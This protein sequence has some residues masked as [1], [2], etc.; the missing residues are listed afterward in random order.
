MKIT[1]EEVRELIATLEKL[2]LYE[3]HPRLSSHDFNVM[4]QLYHMKDYKS[5]NEDYDVRGQLA[6][7]DGSIKNCSSEVAEHLKS[8]LG[9]HTFSNLTSNT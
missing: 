6:M 9:K 8:F 3:G 4:M 5:S 1:L 2:M 7:L